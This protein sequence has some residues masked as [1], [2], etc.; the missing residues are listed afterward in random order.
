MFFVLNIGAPPTIGFSCAVA[1]AA[2]PTHANT[3]ANINFFIT[4]FPFPFVFL[5]SELCQNTGRAPAADCA[6][7]KKS[8]K[9]F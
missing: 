1:S 9:H 2:N 6:G 3:S 5:I 8:Q 4:L 7:E